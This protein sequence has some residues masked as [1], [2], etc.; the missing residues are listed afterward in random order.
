MKWHPSKKKRARNEESVKASRVSGLSMLSDVFESLM[1]SRKQGW[2]YFCIFVFLVIF[3]GAHLAQ[4]ATTLSV[5]NIR[6]TESVHFGTRPA[7]FTFVVFFKLAAWLF[8]ATYM[9]IFIKSLLWRKNA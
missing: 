8:S 2:L 5:P 7:W 4:A 9:A 3:L 1:R 6:T